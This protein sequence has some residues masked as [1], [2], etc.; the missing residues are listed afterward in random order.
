MSKANKLRTAALTR[1]AQQSGAQTSGTATSLTVT[2]VQGIVH[3]DVDVKY[4]LTLFQ[5]LRLPIL[6]LHL[7][8]SRKPMKDGL[9][10]PAHSPLWA[11]REIRSEEHV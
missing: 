8:E 2:P 7:S 6:R 10:P 5:G 4:S 9:L 11:R 1:S 3:S